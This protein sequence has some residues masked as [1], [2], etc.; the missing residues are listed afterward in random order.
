MLTR[1]DGLE[2]YLLGFYI[3]ELDAVD[4]ANV[5]ERVQV[6]VCKCTFLSFSFWSLSAPRR[7]FFRIQG[8]MENELCKNELCPVMRTMDRK[9]Q[10]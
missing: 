4:G 6:F 3:L 5:W 2:E 1:G 7:S 9:V 8:G 10:F